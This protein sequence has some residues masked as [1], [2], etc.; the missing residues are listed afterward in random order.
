MMTRAADLLRFSF[1]ASHWARAHPPTR[2]S[3]RGEQAALKL[4]VVIASANRPAILQQAVEQLDRQTIRPDLVV[5][6]VTSR[7]DLTEHL[8][9]DERFVSIMGSSGLPAQ[10][11]RGIE[12]L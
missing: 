10:R 11:N 8:Q 1:A 7:D 4:A 2:T 9:E 12:A 6:S 3:P 5:L